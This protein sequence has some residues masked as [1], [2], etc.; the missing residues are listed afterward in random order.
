M[1]IAVLTDGIAP[2]VLGGMQRHSYHLVNSLLNLGE[3]ITLVHAVDTDQ[4]IPTEHDVKKHFQ[5]NTDRLHVIGIK[6]PNLDQFPG[7]YLRESYR[8]SCEIFE[9]LKDQWDHF[10]FIYAKGF[11]AW[12]ILEKKS[13][14]LHM[15]PV[16]VKFHGYEM[17]QRTSS[18]KG[19]LEQFMFKPPVV[20]N[21]RSANVVFSYGGEITSIIKKIGVDEN[22]IAE[23]TGGVDDEWLSH[24]ELKVGSPRKFVFVGRNERRKGITD[25]NFAIK[26][27]SDTKAEFH[28]VG[29][30]GK[31]KQLNQPNCVYHGLIRD[32]DRLKSILD[33]MDVLILPSHA[34]GMPNVILEAMA[35]GCAVIAT[36]VGAVSMMV[37]DENGVLIPSNDKSEMVGALESFL[38][39]S[40]SELLKQK[41]ASRQLVRQN[42]LWSEVAKQTQHVISQLTHSSRNGI[43]N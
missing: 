12:C 22:K 36:D 10:D 31:D 1:H 23:I 21:S 26:K 2:F 33:E 9:R 37:S 39:K 5:S 28:W 30:I 4:G 35:R 11:T 3:E 32:S 42:F 34:E 25:L 29:P 8:F 20:F 19:K 41:E 18:I 40:D 15:A 27:V 13:K 17:Y 24:E 14:G 6:F 43:N 7:H 16:G 38:N